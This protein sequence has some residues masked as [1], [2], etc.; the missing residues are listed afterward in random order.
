MVMKMKEGKCTTTSKNVV[1]LLLLVGGLGFLRFTF[2]NPDPPM[3]N[4]TNPRFLPAK[5]SAQ[6]NPPKILIFF[7]LLW[8]GLGHGFFSGPCIYSKAG[9]VQT[10]IKLILTHISKIIWILLDVACALN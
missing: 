9:K 1:V 10:N 2:P 8:F 7:D 4:L 6:L 5:P 3:P